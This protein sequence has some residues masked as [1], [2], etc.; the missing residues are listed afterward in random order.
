MKKLNLITVVVFLAMNLFG[1]NTYESAMK[2][3][4]KLFRSSENLVDMQNVAN[5]FE[6]IAHAEPL[7]W[8]PKYYTAYVQTIIAFQIQNPEEK[9]V[10]LD[11]AQI[12]LDN[13]FEIAP[14]ESELHTLQGMLYQAVIG[15]DPMKNGMEY[16]QKAAACFIKASEYDPGNPRPHYLQGISILNT[17][18][19]W[20]GG[21]EAAKPLLTKAAMLYESFNPETS[22]SPNWGKEDCNRQ[23]QSCL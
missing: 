3:N 7:K 21:K 20:G 1:Q 14:E 10:Y 8:L 9:M 11:A 17:P 2:E 13:A 6:R 5:Q 12:H 19:Q 22:I 4:L 16:S 18:E 23:L 15:V